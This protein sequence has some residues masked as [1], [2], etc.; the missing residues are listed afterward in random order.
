MRNPFIFIL[1][2]LIISSCD[3]F[4]SGSDQN[5]ENGNPVARVG[6][7]FLYDKDLRGLVPP[8]SSSEDSANILNRYID[9]W[10][11]KQ[12]ILKSAEESTNINEAEIARK[13]QD[14][15]YQLIVYNYEKRYIQEKLDTAISEDEI[16]QYYDENRDNFILKQ[17]IIKGILLKVP[18]E[19]P[20]TDRVKVWLRSNS[21][22][23]A[24]KLRSYAYTF[25][26]SYLLDD[27][28]WL[29][30]DEYLYNTPFKEEITNPIQTL[31]RSTLLETSDS[32]HLY[33]IKIKDYKI[34]D[35]H[36]PVEFVKAQIRDVLINKRIVALKK[37]RE[38]EIFEKALKN[39]DYEIYE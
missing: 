20:Q 14:Y 28:V 31:K 4:K 10:V 18:K 29:D 2:I 11:R 38:N 3:F 39:K 36:S 19:A 25:G 21:E 37:E 1:T 30:F 35:Q 17:N 12:L 16:Q 5:P 24:E 15:R 9:S 6:E 34:S 26:D 23:D 33:F 32:T 7:N 27:S 13:M 22:A 8:R